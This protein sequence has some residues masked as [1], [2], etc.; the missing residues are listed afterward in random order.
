MQEMHTIVLGFPVTLRANNQETEEE[1]TDVE[2]NTMRKVLTVRNTIRDL[3][4]D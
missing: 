4:W 3:D 2:N 1:P